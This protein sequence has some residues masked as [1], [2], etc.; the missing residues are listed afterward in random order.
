M[1]SNK[2]SSSISTLSE[3]L[4]LTLIDD[5]VY[6]PSTVSSCCL[7]LVKHFKMQRVQC[8]HADSEL[9]LFSLGMSIAL[10]FR[11]PPQIRENAA[12]AC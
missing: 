8:F 5:E 9:E 10:S 4:P 1:C 12:C 6:K 2:A 7:S 3:H 11:P